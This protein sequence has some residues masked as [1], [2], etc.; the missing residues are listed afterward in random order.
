MISSHR[1]LHCSIPLPLTWI[2]RSVAYRLTAWPEAVVE[3][4]YGDEWVPLAVPAEVLAAAAE[5]GGRAAWRSYFEFLPVAV[6][7]FAALFRTHRI[8][9]L[10]LAARCPELVDAL[11][12]VPALV[13]FVAEQ[14]GSRGP[15]TPRWSEV[16]AVFERGGLFAVL[17]WLG[18]PASRQTLDVLREVVSPELSVTRLRSLRTMLWQPDSIFSFARLP[19]P[20][21]DPSPASFAMAA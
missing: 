14:A 6:R 5:A 20:D 7:E 17:E 2:H 11:A 13:P 3:C 9:A 19:P 4:R 10:Q 12:G 8:A 21:R 18:L 1:R 15:R 16:N